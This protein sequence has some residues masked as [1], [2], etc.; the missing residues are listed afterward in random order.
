[1]SQTLGRAARHLHLDVIGE[2]R[3]LSNSS[4]VDLR[5]VLISSYTTFFDLPEEGDILM[6]NRPYYEIL[7][8]PSG[9]SVTVE[10][11]DPMEDGPVIFTL[12]EIE[13]AD[14]LKENESSPQ[15]MRRLLNYLA[16][17]GRHAERLAIKRQA[18]PVTRRV[19][20]KPKLIRTE[21]GRVKSF[22]TEG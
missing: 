21:K 15:S 10:R 3:C 7:D 14:G 19:E 16:T 18:V 9:A 11:T 22:G 8:L 20:R 13:W 6:S 17:S 4:P 2:E 5:R 12:H 1:M